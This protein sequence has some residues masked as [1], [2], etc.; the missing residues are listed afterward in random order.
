MKEKTIVNNEYLKEKGF[1]YEH[2]TPMYTPNYI[3]DRE[4]LHKLFSV[5]CNPINAFLMLFVYCLILSIIYHGLSLN[6]GSLVAWLGI[7]IFTVLDILHY[8]FGHKK[9][10]LARQKRREE[11]DKERKFYFSKST[12]AEVLD[13]KKGVYRY[14]TDSEETSYNDVRETRSFWID[15]Q[16]KLIDCSCYGKTKRKEIFHIFTIRYTSEDSE[17]R[18]ACIAFNSNQY[19]LDEADLKIEKKYHD[20]VTATIDDNK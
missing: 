12:K 16:K 19:I 6:A 9:E 1:E 10:E 20:N 17:I 18:D 7:I 8:K 14:S 3:N 4:W 2:G 11:Y 13:Y 5:I 15:G